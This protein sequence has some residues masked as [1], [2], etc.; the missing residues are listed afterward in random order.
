M[1]GLSLD[2]GL[3]FAGGLSYI[4]G[5]AVG[6]KGIADIAGSIVFTVDKAAYV[7][8]ANPSTTTKS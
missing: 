3:S 2:H 1:H 4:H 6:G 5:L 7:V 8:T